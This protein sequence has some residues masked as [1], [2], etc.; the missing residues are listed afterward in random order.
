MRR[1]L[2]AVRDRRGELRMRRSLAA[3]LVALSHGSRPSCSSPRTAATPRTRPW[4]TRSPTSP[5]RR[6][7]GPPH[8]LDGATAIA[9]GR[10]RRR[11]H[12]QRRH[13]PPTRL[14]PWRCATCSSRCRARRHASV[15]AA[16]GPPRP[17]HRRRPRPVRRRLHRARQ[18]GLRRANLHPL[19]RP[20]PGTPRRAGAG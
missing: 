3:A 16:R 5:I 11:R 17:A 2:H 10:R 6:S 1:A 7:R 4:S 15:E 9:D 13:R 12:G 14:P 18:A 20:A 19:G 8:A